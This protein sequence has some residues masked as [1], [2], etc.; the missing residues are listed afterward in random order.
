MEADGPETD[1]PELCRQ[2]RHS[3]CPVS[4]SSLWRS[5]CTLPWLVSTSFHNTWVAA[6]TSFPS[7]AVASPALLGPHG[8]GRVSSAQRSDCGLLP[9]WFKAAADGPSGRA[10]RPSY[11]ADVTL[12][13]DEVTCKFWGLRRESKQRQAAH[14]SHAHSLSRVQG[15]PPPT[16]EDE[17]GRQAEHR[18][19]EGSARHLV[20]AGLT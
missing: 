15:R 14:E 9:A 20:R 12:V 13:R 8:E 19:R 4:P 2:V 5:H 17:P 10:D 3:L 18:A 16:W 1:K 11:C 6:S 7:S